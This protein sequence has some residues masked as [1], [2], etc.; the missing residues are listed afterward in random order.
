[1]GGGPPPVYTAMAMPTPAKKEKR[2]T[3]QSNL[4]DS[5]LK[6]Q[7]SPQLAFS[8]S[9]VAGEFKQDVAPPVPPVPTLLSP[10]H[11][12]VNPISHFDGKSQFDTYQPQLQQK[13]DE[14]EQDTHLPTPKQ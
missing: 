5:M 9:L 1:M 11:T 14:E 3:E 4:V 8:P 6:S 2:W 13:E 7:Y 12:L 10:S